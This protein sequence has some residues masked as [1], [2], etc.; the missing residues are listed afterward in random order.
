[1]QSVDSLVT[2]LNSSAVNNICLKRSQETVEIA[3]YFLLRGKLAAAAETHLNQ[4]MQYCIY[5][6]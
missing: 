1:M 5:T 2:G 6:V 4:S 3:G